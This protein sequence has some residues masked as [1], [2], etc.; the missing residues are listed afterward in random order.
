[1]K[2]DKFY[3]KEEVHAMHLSGLIRALI[4]QETEC[5]DEIKAL[6]GSEKDMIPFIVKRYDSNISLLQDELDMREEFF[7]AYHPPVKFH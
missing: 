1:M 6:D 3:S 7:S 5:R 2:K 4:A